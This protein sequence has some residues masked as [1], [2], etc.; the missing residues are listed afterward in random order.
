MRPSIIRALLL[1]I[2]LVTVSAPAANA[3]TKA[4][5]KTR[6][7]VEKFIVGKDGVKALG[8]ATSRVG[9]F[10]RTRRVV[11]KV[12]TGGT[13]S[14]LDVSIKELHLTLLGLDVN[15][16]AINLQITGN[17]KQTLGR[18]FCRLSRSLSLKTSGR[19]TKRLVRS[20]NH[21]L[22]GRPMPTVS[23]SGVMTRQQTASEYAPCE[24]LNLVLGPVHVDLL[25]LIVDLFGPTKKDPITA[26]VT[27]DPNRG[28]LGQK[29]CELARPQS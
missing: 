4:R 23:F 14:V 20:L 22:K 29:F 24:V 11:M 2:A 28:V 6:V 17:S 27:A 19:G 5:M 8:F 12:K 25:G 26:V 1:A 16:S 15:A 18:L 13:C 21:H 10:H 7:K 9:E 3:A